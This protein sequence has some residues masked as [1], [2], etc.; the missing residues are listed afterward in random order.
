MRPSWQRCSVKPI[1]GP[2]RLTSV[3]SCQ[4]ILFLQHLLRSPVTSN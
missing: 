4:Y 3:T 2:S 1:E